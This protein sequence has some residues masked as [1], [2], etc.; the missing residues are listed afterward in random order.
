MQHHLGSLVRRDIL[1][2]YAGKDGVVLGRD[3]F[4]AKADDLVDNRGEELVEGIL[5]CLAEP[6]IPCTDKAAV[7]QIVQSW[8]DLTHGDADCAED[9]RQETTDDKEAEHLRGDLQIRR[10]DGCSEVCEEYMEHIPSFAWCNGKCGRSRSPE[11]REGAGPDLSGLLLMTGDME[12]AA[13]SREHSDPKTNFGISDDPDVVARACWYTL[14]SSTTK[15][16]SS[17]LG[18]GICASMVGCASRLRDATVAR[19]LLEGMSPLMEDSALYS[20]RIRY[21]AA[22]SILDSCAESKTGIRL[23]AQGLRS[24]SERRGVGENAWARL[25]MR[26][27]GLLCRVCDYPAA[28]KHSP[29]S[30]GCCC[31][32][33]EACVVAQVALGISLDIERE[34]EGGNFGG[35]ENWMGD[36]L[37]ALLT[38]S[39]W[40][41]DAAMEDA[42]RT[43]ISALGCAWRGIYGFSQNVHEKSMEKSF[44]ENVD[45]LLLWSTP[46]NTPSW[47]DTKAQ[48]LAMDASVAQAIRELEEERGYVLGGKRVEVTRL[49]C[50]VLGRLAQEDPSSP[51][52][53]AEGLRGSTDTCASGHSLRI[54]NALSGISGFALTI[55]CETEIYAKMQHILRRKIMEHDEDGQGLLLEQLEGLGRGLSMIDDSHAELRKLYAAVIGSV[56]LEQMRREYIGNEDPEHPD[57]PLMTASEYSEAFRTAMM[58]YE[59]LLQT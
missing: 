46:S 10:P 48:L 39:K 3:H 55:S 51:S 57:D 9:L 37:D 8:C 22:C 18:L 27:L 34:I 16:L 2:R 24:I 29:A 58:K 32:G 5:G 59:G 38:F 28:H 26:A 25:P 4:I 53:L 40:I 54:V 21:Q 31:G 11:H 42:V 15:T 17:E 52:L 1:E 7:V 19:A 50:M 33:G 6:S 23:V 49:A 12:K 41:R 14:Q 36:A 30:T 47:N 43:R 56:E 35:D 20:D 44:R 45:K 13:G